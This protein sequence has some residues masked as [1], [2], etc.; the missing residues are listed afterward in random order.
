M[1]SYLQLLEEK[2][3]HSFNVWSFSEKFPMKSFVYTRNEKE[4][5]KHICFVL[6][7]YF[8]IVSLPH[9]YLFFFILSV[10]SASH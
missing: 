2:T 4:N 5:V 7:F 10:K 1:N 3:S 9:V 6:F 8:Y